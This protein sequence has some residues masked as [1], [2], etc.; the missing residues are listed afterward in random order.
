MNPWEY[1][2]EDF[3]RQHGYACCIDCDKPFH[4]IACLLKH[5]KEHY[6][7]EVKL[8]ENRDSQ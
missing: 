2:D 1:Y 5:Q 7:K 8:R 6:D 4:Y 3:F